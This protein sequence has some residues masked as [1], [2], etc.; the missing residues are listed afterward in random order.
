M[1]KAGKLVAEL[2]GRVLSVAS[3]LP[4]RYAMVWRY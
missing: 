3:Y 2:A 4:G 1:C